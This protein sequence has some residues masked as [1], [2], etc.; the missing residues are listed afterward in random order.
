MGSVAST[1]EQFDAKAGDLRL[2]DGRVGDEII[3]FWT[4]GRQGARRD[5]CARCTCA[6]LLFTA[7]ITKF[8]LD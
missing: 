6:N 1:A 3:P 7:Q 5:L 2:G 4:P 8:F